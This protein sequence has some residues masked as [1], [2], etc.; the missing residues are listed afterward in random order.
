MSKK[1]LGRG[2]SEQGGQSD[3][4][5][6]PLDNLPKNAAD[7]SQDECQGASSDKSQDLSLAESQDHL[8]DG[9]VAPGHESK[10]GVGPA[11]FTNDDLPRRAAMPAKPLKPLKPLKPRASQ[12]RVPRLSVAQPAAPPGRLQKALFNYLGFFV[13]LIACF[14]F[15]LILGFVGGAIIGLAGLKAGTTLSCII[16]ALLFG[17]MS[18]LYGFLTV[19]LTAFFFRHNAVV[20]RHVTSGAI[21]FW[22]LASTLYIFSIPKAPAES[23]AVLVGCICNALSQYLTRKMLTR[24]K[25]ALHPPSA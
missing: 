17:S 1:R 16:L 13:H 3:L 10:S 24:H 5:T 12:T 19:K 15:T 2:K 9:K 11:A 21:G 14:P 4:P 8:I 6:E 18:M 20:L 22:L 23:V 7:Q 25:P